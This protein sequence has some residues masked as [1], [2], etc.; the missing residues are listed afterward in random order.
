MR[1]AELVGTE[2]VGP[3][4]VCAAMD[5]GH[6]LRIDVT[7]W[8]LM[9]LFLQSLLV[10]WVKT[11]SPV[12]SGKEDNLYMHLV[13]GILLN[14]VML[15]IDPRPNQRFHQ[16]VNNHV[17]LRIENLTILVR[18]IKTFYQEVLQQLIVMSLP[19]VF[20]IGKDPLSGE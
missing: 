20:M 16:H 3:E 5:G 1:G 8:K 19:D 2:T 11:L 15:E 13:D 9:E 10:A 17:N 7:V 6:S 14:Q 18:H 12:A 4:P